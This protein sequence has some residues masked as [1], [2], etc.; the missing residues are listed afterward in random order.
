VSYFTN[1]TVKLGF[2]EKIYV[3]IFSQNK[4]IQRSCFVFI[5]NISH[6]SLSSGF[7]SE[8]E[9]SFKDIDTIEML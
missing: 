5:F 4:I 9:F 1:F 7:T 6:F 2:T 8:L 3:I